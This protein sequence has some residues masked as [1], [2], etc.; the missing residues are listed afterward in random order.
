MTS[1]PI[2]EVEDEMLKK[3]IA[4]FGTKQWV[5]S[6]EPALELESHSGG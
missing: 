6:W 3:S 5:F 1:T 2:I 4:L